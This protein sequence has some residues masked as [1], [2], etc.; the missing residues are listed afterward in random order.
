[1]SYQ[2]C[3]KYNGHGVIIVKHPSVINTISNAC[4]VCNGKMIISTLTGQP[5]K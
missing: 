2:I 5:P 4:P 1:M 3:P